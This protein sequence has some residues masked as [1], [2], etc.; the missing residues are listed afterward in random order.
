MEDTKPNL[1]ILEHIEISEITLTKY[2]KSLNTCKAT[3][4]DCIIARIMQ[5]L[6]DKLGLILKILFDSSMEE[7]VIPSQWKNAHVTALFKKGSKW[8]PD[9]YRPVR[10][11]SICL[12]KIIR[13][14]IIASI[15]KQGL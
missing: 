10:L 7:G 4:P 12:K 15:D 8:S 3:G 1:E 5:E 9:N 6:V 14:A 11:T 2:L 13:N